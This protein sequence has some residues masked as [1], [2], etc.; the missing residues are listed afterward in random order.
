MIG[1][2]IRDCQGQLLVDVVPDRCSIS[3]WSTSYSMYQ[4]DLEAALHNC[5]EAMP[6][7]GICSAGRWRCSSSMTTTSR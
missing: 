7:V 4:P 2:G 5:L 1:G 6:T 3:G